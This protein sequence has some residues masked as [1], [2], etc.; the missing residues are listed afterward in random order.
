MHLITIG[1]AVTSSVDRNDCLEQIQNGFLLLGFITET[2]KQIPYEKC[3]LWS[4]TTTEHELP[5]FGCY[6]LSFTSVLIKLEMSSVFIYFIGDEFQLII[7]Y[8]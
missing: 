2:E 8:V 3:T 4:V 5:K 6:F 1:S 7:P